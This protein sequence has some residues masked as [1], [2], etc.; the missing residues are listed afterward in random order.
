MQK[1]RKVP[2]RY[3]LT[4]S[5][6]A[7]YFSE[8][9]LEQ[10]TVVAIGL[11]LPILIL[12]WT[13]FGLTAG[14]FTSW[15]VA[16]SLYSMGFAEPALKDVVSLSAKFFTGLNG[17]YF[18]LLIVYFV[19]TAELFRAPEILRQVLIIQTLL[20]FLRYFQMG[21]PLG[22]STI[23]SLNAAFTAVLSPFAFST[24]KENILNWMLFFLAATTVCVQEGVIA[25]CLIVA[26]GAIY[27]LRSLNHIGS[28]VVCISIYCLVLGL[29]VLHGQDYGDGS[30]FA[31]YR[32]AIDLVKS[33]GVLDYGTGFGSFFVLGTVGIRQAGLGISEF[34]PALHSDIV[35]LVCE[36]GWIGGLLGFLVWVQAVVGGFKK[37]FEGGLS[38][39]GVGLFAAF[40]Y[41][42]HV[43][44]VAIFLA[45]LVF[46][47][48]E[49]RLPHKAAQSGD[50]NE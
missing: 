30:R 5:I 22:L 10:V 12:V 45:M 38:L 8:P 21:T 20:G 48:L 37:S 19:H 32:S 41:P 7:A 50:D 15:V 31:V 14:L 47:S 17:I 27:V 3:F 36:S 13:R 2:G 29:C 1:L 6:F 16:S 34:W 4:I 42:F 25:R 18:V 39:L 28:R 23:I 33:L 24:E 40:Y 43:P 9:F 49:Q 46:W 44:I 26:F 35:Q 11:A